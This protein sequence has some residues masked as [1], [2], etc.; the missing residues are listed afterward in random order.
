MALV[1]KNPAQH[2]ATQR[3]DR[4]V[5]SELMAFLKKPSAHITEAH[6]VALSEVR[7][8]PKGRPV[9]EKQRTNYALMAVI[10]GLRKACGGMPP[11]ED[12][13]ELLKISLDLGHPEGP[14][15]VLYSVSDGV[16][17]TPSKDWSSIIT[18]VKALEGVFKPELVAA[19]EQDAM[20]PEGIGFEF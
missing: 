11:L 17:R 1:Y 7:A 13:K 2:E 5:V 14:S 12:L 10:P 4:E 3:A 18:D 15:E 8:A 19:I 16:K 6:K 20:L 9:T